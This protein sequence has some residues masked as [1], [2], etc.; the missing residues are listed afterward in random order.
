MF[1][2]ENQIRL[3]IIAKVEYV[4]T[5]LVIKYSIVS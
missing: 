3:H 2:L 4:I 5:L 1:G